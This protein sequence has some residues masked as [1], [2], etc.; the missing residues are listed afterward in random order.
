MASEARR[1]HAAPL[2]ITFDEHPAA[3]LRGTSAPPLLTTTDERLRLLSEE[4]GE[5]AV[6]LLPF[7]HALAQ[8]TAAQFMRRLHDEHNVRTLVLG[9]DHRFGHDRLAR[10]T[11]YQ[12]AGQDI[13]IDIVRAQEAPSPA[14]I[15]SS[16]I[17]NLLLD[18]HV[19]T[20]AQLLS[21]PYFLRGNVVGGFHIGRQLGYPTANIQPLS[22]RKLIPANGVYDVRVALADT[23]HHGMLYIGHRPTFNGQEKTIEAHLFHFHDNLYDQQVRIDFIRFIRPERTFSSPEQLQQQLRQDQQ[24]C[25]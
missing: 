11:D 10:F 23:T 21:R 18:G 22:P 19:E 5:E 25:L 6:L 13:G 12:R 2:I 16:R 14:P 17:R 15:S 7:T 8:L 1:R 4:T 20:A 9:Y 3:V 24:A